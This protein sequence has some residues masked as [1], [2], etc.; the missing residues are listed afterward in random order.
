[1]AN[2]GDIVLSTGNGI[3]TGT[4]GLVNVAKGRVKSAGTAPTTSSTGLG[5]G[6]IAVDTGST[7]YAAC[8]TIT[9]GSTSTATG[10]ITLTLTGALATNTP[11][12]ISTLMNG[13]GSWNARATAI[14]GSGTSTTQV[15]VS[16]DNNA[17]NLANGS[18]YKVCILT[19]GK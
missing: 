2:G 16:W 13:T 9:G 18:T 4:V 17:V 6:S 11:V 12:A 14:I 15:T 3:G 8:V 7:D 10:V 1:N 19:V 5:N